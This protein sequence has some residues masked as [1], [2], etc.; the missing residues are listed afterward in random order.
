MAQTSA[1]SKKFNIYLAIAR[2]SENLCKLL[3]GKELVPVTEK[4]KLSQKLK[5][6]KFD[7]I[8]VEYEIS[9]KFY[10][11][12]RN[13]IIGA[14]LVPRKENESSDAV[15][16]YINIYRI[17]N[18][19]EA[20]IFIQTEH[21]SE[22][23]MKIIGHGKSEDV[24]NFIRYQSLSDP[25]KK[26]RLETLFSALNENKITCIS[27]SVLIFLFGVSFAKVMY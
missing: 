22:G 7:G 27:A 21:G 17:A 15:K 16:F 12:D 5:D 11:A 1:D 3:F 24:V 10:I 6:L 25:C 14:A 9:R 19:R 4:E 18:Q 26:D 13:D 20:K 8:D 23:E 2:A